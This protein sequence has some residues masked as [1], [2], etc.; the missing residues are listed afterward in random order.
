MTQRRPAP[1]GDEQSG[2]AT[3]AHET[4]KELPVEQ[5]IYNQIVAF[6]WGIADDVLRDL[7][8]RGKYPDLILPMCVLRRMDGA[9]APTK[10]AVLDTRQ[11]LD[12]AH[13]TEQGQITRSALLLLL[14]R[15]ELAHFLSPVD[16][17]I[18][19]LLRD[20]TGVTGTSMHFGMPLRIAN[21]Q[22]LRPPRAAARPP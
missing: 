9:L 12:G 1:E 18:T 20:A 7:F 17:K 4:L 2:P 15:D 8:K 14:G 21:R 16:A 19:W 13:I 10:Q 5:A 22:M 6:I 11:M 3:F